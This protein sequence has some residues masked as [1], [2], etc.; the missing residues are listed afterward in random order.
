MSVTDPR[1][2]TASRA[3]FMQ[4]IVRTLTMAGVAGVPQVLIGDRDRKWSR[5]VRRRLRDAGIRVVLI[6][7]RAPKANA[8]AERFVRS[9]KKECLDRLIPL[10][11]QHFRRAVAEYVEHYHGK[12][13]HQGLGNRLI[14]GSPLID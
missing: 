7:A 10:G 3:L 11:A 2:Y 12:R 1:V 5:D 13:N 4:Q 8:Y 9:I 14:A 6:P